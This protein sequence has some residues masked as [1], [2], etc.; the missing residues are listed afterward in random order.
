MH[1][2]DAAARISEIDQLLMDP[3]VVSNQQRLKEVSQERARLVPIVESWVAL[4]KARAELKDTKE[5]LEDPEM[6]EM[7]QEEYDHLVQE[8]EVLQKQ[9]RMALIP[10]D[11]YEGRDIL[12]EIRAGTGGDEAGLFA[13]D[14]FRMYMR[15]CD[16]NR[17]KTELI[18][19]SDLTAGGTKAGSQFF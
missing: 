7:A 11:P 2:R 17:W 4:T 14:L 8:V 1:P 13:G 19:S 18:S 9:L 16:A 15:Y 3:D 12:V 6:R 5:L 10:P